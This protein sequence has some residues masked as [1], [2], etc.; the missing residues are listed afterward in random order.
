MNYDPMSKCI[1][2]FKFSKK[3]YHLVEPKDL[4]LEAISPALDNI[5]TFI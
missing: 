1:T 3:I 5:I 4:H 2:K